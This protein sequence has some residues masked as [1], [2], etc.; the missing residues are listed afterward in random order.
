[1]SCHKNAGSEEEKQENEKS[2][3]V[4][5]NIG[6]KYRAR[7]HFKAYIYVPLRS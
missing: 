2:V 7:N 1:M 6:E 4:L 3:V 5:Q